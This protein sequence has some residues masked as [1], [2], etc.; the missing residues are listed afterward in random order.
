MLKQKLENLVENRNFEIH[1]HDIISESI[2]EFNNSFLSFC[3]QALV[4]GL[5]FIKLKKLL[6]EDKVWGW[7]EW[8]AKNITIE[9]KRNRQKYMKLA[10]REE[11]FQYTFLGVD[12]LD[13]LCSVTK[14]NPTCKTFS[15]FFEK[16][17]ISDVTKENIN[18]I[19]QIDDAINKERGK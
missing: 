12:R 4:K 16:H 11:C 5:Y 2:M 10:R 18:V 14:N 3:E 19:H 17:S 13:Y 9:S 8:A 7:G 15:E 1:N 6:F